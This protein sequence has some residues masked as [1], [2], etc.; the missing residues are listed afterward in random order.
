M[1]VTARD[2][3]AALIEAGKTLEEI[4]DADPTAGLYIKGRSWLSPKL[5]ILSVYADLTR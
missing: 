4:V 1:L 5:F 3:I 2:R